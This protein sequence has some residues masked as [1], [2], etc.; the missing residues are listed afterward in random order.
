MSPTTPHVP[1]VFD[2]TTA[3]GGAAGI[4]TPNTARLE[5]ILDAG[6]RVTFHRDAANKMYAVTLA[7]GPMHVTRYHWVYESALAYTLDNW[8]SGL[9][10]SSESASL[11][12]GNAER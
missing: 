2:V 12:L 1:E 7:C 3:Q 5:R 10:D 6:V 4:T 9:L 11:P 8:E